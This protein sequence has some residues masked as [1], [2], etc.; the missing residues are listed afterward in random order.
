MVMEC[1]KATQNLNKLDREVKTWLK[2]CALLAIT[3]AMN[4]K[5]NNKACFR[6]S[7]SVVF[8][9]I[10]FLV[11]WR[12]QKDVKEYMQYSLSFA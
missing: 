9:W 4:I 6:V 11:R 1:K 5:E 10:H 3:G 2:Q 7:T 8:E 12:V